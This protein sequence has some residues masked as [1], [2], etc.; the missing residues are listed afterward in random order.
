MPLLV[1]GP[2]S[3]FPTDSTLSPIPNKHPQMSTP[4]GCSDSREP[5]VTRSRLPF[6][7]LGFRVHSCWLQKAASL[8]PTPQPTA[9]HPG[10][11][12]SPIFLCVLFPLYP[13]LSKNATG[14]IH[15]L[16]HSPSLPLKPGMLTQA[17]QGLRIP[18]T[19]SVS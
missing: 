5:Q 18:R 16:H 9:C 4:D 8:K 17:A 2:S 1:L 10:R 13:S 3:H 7:I 6:H 11:S 14:Y 19:I 15:L 12:R